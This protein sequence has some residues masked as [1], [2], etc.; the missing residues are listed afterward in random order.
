[1]KVKVIE[2]HQ[3]K[4]KFVAWKITNYHMFIYIISSSVTIYMT[5]I[6]FRQGYC[7]PFSWMVHGHRDIAL[8]P[9]LSCNCHIQ[10]T[11]AR[12]IGTCISFHT[13]WLVLVDPC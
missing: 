12:H 2:T 7:L 5:I 11:T 9:L 1:M 6:V 8:Y 13:R 4:S 10:H 3:M